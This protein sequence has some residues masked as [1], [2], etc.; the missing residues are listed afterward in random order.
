MKP[1]YTTPSESQAHRFLGI[2]PCASI[3]RS[4]VSC[5]KPFAQRSRAIPA[6]FRQ[7]KGLGP[8][9]NGG[10]AADRRSPAI[11]GYSTKSAG[12]AVVKLPTV[13]YKT[14]S[15]IIEALSSFGLVPVSHP[16]RVVGADR[17]AQSLA[18]GIANHS[19]QGARGSR[20]APSSPEAGAAKVPAAP[21]AAGK[22]ATESLRGVWGG[23]PSLTC[24]RVNNC[25]G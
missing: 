25:V 20:S 24:V 19:S 6:R 10:N 15:G 1:L 17:G 5:G 12:S 16:G 3:G 18:E 14:R 22:A 13:A 21:C 4:A 9:N 11:P 7:A 2:P 8:R 23:A